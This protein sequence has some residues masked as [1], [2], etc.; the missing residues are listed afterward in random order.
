MSKYMLVYTGGR[1]PESDAEQKA[2]LNDW[3]T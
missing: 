2:V 1:M 3:E